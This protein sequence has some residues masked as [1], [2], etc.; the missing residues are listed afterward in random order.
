MHSATK[1][2]VAKAEKL[3]AANKLGDAQKAVTQAISA[4]DKAAQK[5]V[6]HPR[7]AARRKSRLMKKL[8][9]A[10]KE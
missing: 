3:I 9:S 1:T 7:N 4:L 2:C 10:S 5:R 8:N 6:I